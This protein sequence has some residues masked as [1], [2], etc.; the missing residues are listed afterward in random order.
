MKIQLIL[1]FLTAGGA[2]AVA[3][4]TDELVADKPDML[5]VV[6]DMLVTDSYSDDVTSDNEGGVSEGQ[7]W[8]HDN[9]QWQSGVG[10]TGSIRDAQESDDW[11]GGSHV[12]GSTNVTSSQMT[13][14]AD[15]SGTEVFTA[16]DGSS[17][18]YDVALPLL[19]SEHCLIN[20]PQS[21]PIVVQVLGSSSWV[22]NQAQEAYLRSA[23][24]RWRLQT[25]GRAGGQSV[26]RLSGVAARILDK[27]AQR[28]FYEVNSQPIAPRSI[29]VM[30]RALYADGNLW[31]VL[32][33]G[34]NLD[35]TPFVASQD[36]YTMSLT[37]QKYA[38]CITVNNVSLNS[39][40]PEFC[41]GQYL[42]F[43]LA[44]DPPPDYVG[45]VSQ[46]N[47]PGAPINESWRQSPGGS[48]N[49]R[50][51]QSLL[52]NLTTQCW[53]SSGIGGMASIGT[54]LQFSNGQYC[55]FAV[56]GNFSLSKPVFSGFDSLPSL[57]GFVWSSPVLE[58]N[59]QWSVTVQSDY[60]GNVGVTQLI[61]GTNVCCNTGG[62]YLLDGGSDI[63]NPTTTAP[64]GQTYSAANPATHL[65]TLLGARSA[66][67]SPAVDMT[68]LFKDYLRFRPA[69]NQSNIWV[70]LAT[71]NWSMDGSASLPGGL[72]RSNL[73]PA[74]VL[75]G[76]EELPAWPQSFGQ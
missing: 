66:T 44:F 74:S 53:Y 72:T 26:F 2:L 33:N 22:T 68:A 37:E 35:V 18:T 16:N 59:M 63:Y 32:P 41:V 56:L 11:D 71:N 25:G 46:W 34:T 6:G 28:P 50:L 15:G 54:S 45:Q 17:V 14:A 27:R 51:N 62:V 5:Y 75:I 4:I 65:F 38:P 3:S 61:N 30:G 67:A 12:W 49:Y 13:W 58:A 40:T 39:G 48:V 76:S 20:D 57:A 8:H 1:C 70:T 42:E 9:Y 21:P 31:R 29:S 7:L 60:D 36:F 69:G 10:G 23:Q 47:L 73:P 19:T 55:C 64:M 52:T 43:H 24:T